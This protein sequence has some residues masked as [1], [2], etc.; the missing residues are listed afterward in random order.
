MKQLI[1]TDDYR[2]AFFYILLDTWLETNGIFYESNQVKL[3]TNEFFE[4]QNPLK[5][6]FENNY[7]IDRECQILV[8]DMWKN[9]N[10]SKEYIGDKV[11]SKHLQEIC[12]LRKGT[13]NKNYAFCK[14][15]IVSV[16]SSE[17]EENEIV[18]LL[19][20]YLPPL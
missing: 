2:D 13:G 4:S 12:K 15:K 20:R 14:I 8:K 16:D 3:T 17:I 1:S 19:P 9:H 7:E 11:F 18:R 5:E 6:W 10:D